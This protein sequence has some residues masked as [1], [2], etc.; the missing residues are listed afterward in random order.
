MNLK[1][2]LGLLISLLGAGCSVKSP[3]DRDYVSEGIKEH[4]TFEL[5]QGIEPG[6]WSVPEGMSLENGL[7]QDE[8]VAL[9]LWNNAQFQADLSALGFA[10]ADLL[11]ANMLPN[12]VFSLFFPVGPKLLETRLAMPIEALWQRPER[13]A[14]AHLNAEAVAENLI[15]HGLGFVREVQAAYV[16][17][18]RATER[19]RLAQE[20]AA[21]STEMADLAWKRMRSGD[22]S[23]FEAMQ[24]KADSL[25]VTESLQQ[26]QKE[27]ALATHRLLSLMGIT[28]NRE[29]YMFVPPD[30]MKD[31][32][33]PQETLETLAL[34]ARPDL[35]AMELNIE[36]AG[37]RLGWEKSK[38]YQFIAMI[39]GKDKG[40]SS[41]TIG[42]G[43][44]TE[45]PIF[46][47]N[48]GAVARAHTELDQAA[49][50]YEAKRHEILLQV[51]E[52]YTQY[53]STREALALWQDETVPC[54]KQVESQIQKACDAGELSYVSVLTAR[55]KVL[56][57]EVRSS[58]LAADLQHCAVQLNYAV[59]KK[60]L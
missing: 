25:R 53:I 55:Q 47:Q 33:V 57:A 24:A 17:V 21:L 45:I 44:S 32:Q 54:L 2:C 31:A 27:K 30:P 12:P 40:A 48:N 3:Y 36:A 41:I 52:A 51:K 28:E 46:N 6:K 49:W 23:E 14:A 13:L 56:E 37:K 22:S 38:V 10:R 50:A 9:A 19:T 29:N 58:T 34:A 18:W 5:G 26:C 60:M 15:E 42:P 43:L 20:E 4:A 39:D 11:E 59:G 16:A 1:V 7:T 35:R 8:C